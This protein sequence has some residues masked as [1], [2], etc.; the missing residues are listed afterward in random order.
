MSDSPLV[1][2]F[3]QDM[4]GIAQILLM[5]GHSIDEHL[6]YELLRQVLRLP[7]LIARDSKAQQHCNVERIGLVKTN[8]RLQKTIEEYEEQFQEQTK[9]LSE[10]SCYMETCM[11]WMA[12]GR[13]L[14]LIICSE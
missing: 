9:L 5:Q 11:R 7:I 14:Q 8:H 2:E 1:V 6:L 12:L 13:Y 10:T 3:V 4:A